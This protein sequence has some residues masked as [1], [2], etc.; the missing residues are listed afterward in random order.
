MSANARVFT[1]TSE[2]G[3]VV[4]VTSYG[5]I[6]M[7]ILAPDRD[8]RLADVVLGHDT[9]LAYR[10]NP[11]YLG[12]IIGRC[13]NRIA[14]AQFTVDDR[15]YR[16][17]ANDGPHS[18]HGGRNG[19]DQA[20]WRAEEFAG[21]VRL[22]HRSP[23]ADQGYPGNTDVTVAYTVTA[24]NELIV[25]YHAVTDQATPVNLTQHSYFNLAGGG[26]ILGHLL[27]VDADLITPVD[28]AM[29]PTGELSPVAGGPFDFRAP[30]PIARGCDINF[31]L[32]GRAE[33]PP[34]RRAA[35]LADPG[36]GRWLEVFTT[37]P[38]V[39][40]YTGNYLEVPRT[41]VCL[42]TQHYPDSPNQQGFPSVILRPGE[43]Y[44]SRTVFRFGCQL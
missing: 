25:D 13:A 3:L 38:G 34:L 26:D 20:H 4:R 23:D 42:E 24:G 39:Q 16:L 1:L 44:R 37:E 17:S 10:D 9:A 12:A 43:E 41:G 21:G 28:E 5:G 19:F 7:S 22:S 40:V 8:G 14:N 31:V 11:S 2:G 29:I 33:S 18:L 15:T 30:R 6:I 27:Q 32:R 35:R 36:S